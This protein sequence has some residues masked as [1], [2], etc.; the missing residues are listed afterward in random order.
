MSETALVK[1]GA[2]PPCCLFVR[3][4][5]K[6]TGHGTSKRS[7]GELSCVKLFRRFLHLLEYRFLFEGLLPASAFGECLESF[8]VADGDFGDTNGPV[9]L[10]Q[11]L[12]TVLVLVLASE[13]CVSLSNSG[14][15]GEE[16]VTGADKE[17]SCSPKKSS[18]DK[19]DGDD[20]N[21]LASSVLCCRRWW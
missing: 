18:L 16:G 15:K 9:V 14:D 12:L 1:A 5:L 2:A 19:R 6:Y 7:V 8:L 11:L 3:D 10:L 4:L 20:N 17:K 21:V 13:S